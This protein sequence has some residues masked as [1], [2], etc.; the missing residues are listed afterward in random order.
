MIRETR[1]LHCDR[2]LKPVTLTTAENV[3]MYPEPLPTGW[4][5]A[6]VHLQT[7]GQDGNLGRGWDLCPPCAEALQSH[8]KLIR[9]QLS[10]VLT[11]FQ[12]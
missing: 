10:D 5:K 4:V 1:T 6:H 7:H 11:A 12:S 9:Q 8:I 2:C 3:R